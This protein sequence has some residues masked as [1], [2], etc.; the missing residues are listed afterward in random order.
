M[1]ERGA[2]TQKKTATP[3]EHLNE[4]GG[5][6]LFIQLF[7]ATAEVA[8]W[9]ANSIRLL[10]A[11]KE[12]AS[13]KMLPTLHSAPAASSKLLPTLNSASKEAASWPA[14]VGAAE[15]GAAEG[16]VG[17][18]QSGVEGVVGGIDGGTR[19]RPAPS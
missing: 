8:S 19:P 2:H 16:F 10:S 7:S 11:P 1:G 18:I 12:A 3:L 13:S 4:A 5:D 15:V 6:L 14:G 17:G 9:S